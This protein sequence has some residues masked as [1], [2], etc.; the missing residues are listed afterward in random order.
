VRFWLALSRD[1]QARRN[2]RIGGREAEELLRGISTTGDREE[3]L[4]LLALAAAP[5]Q[6][7]ELVGHDAALAAFR[8]APEPVPARPRR[9]RWRFASRALLVKLVA[10]AGVLLVGGAA[11]AAGTG[12]LPTGVQHGAHNL[13]SPLG[14]QVPDAT[15]P[16]TASGS[17][18]SL[19]TPAPSPPPPTPS[20]STPAGLCQAWRAAKGKPGKG[21]EP[22]Q[23]QALIQAAGGM[24]RVP[25]FC[26]QILGP[27]PSAPPSPTP[28]PS[29]TPKS[30]PSQKPSH[31]T[32]SKGANPSATSRR[33]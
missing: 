26:A 3:L 11:V 16:G 29:K 30:H 25:A 14:V 1:R 21:M 7:D 20:T 18:H 9:H 31:P 22:S 33:H 27:D 5:P 2:R 17:V 10:G 6:P 13:L 28:H 19:R 23:R 24:D 15:G 12:S 32:K 8:A 4:R